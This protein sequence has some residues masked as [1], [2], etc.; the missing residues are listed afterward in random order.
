MKGIETTGGIMT[1]LINR[2]TL[3]PTRKSQIFSTT[4]DNQPTV[5]I[6]VYEGERSLTRDNN[7]LG[8]FELS[9]IPAAARGV[10]QIEVAFE[11]DADGILTVS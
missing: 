4:A 3:I 5:L 1:K 6:Q 10:P 2:G 8:K 7:M 11:L 9:D